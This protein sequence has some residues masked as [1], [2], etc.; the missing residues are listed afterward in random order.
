MPIRDLTQNPKLPTCPECGRHG[1]QTNLWN[2]V[3]V[4]HAYRMSGV[5]KVLEDV[6]WYYREGLSPQDLRQRFPLISAARVAPLEISGSAISHIRPRC[7]QYAEQHNCQAEMEAELNALIELR[8][9]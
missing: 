3:E 2:G 1:T 9:F 8:G 5:F 4:I 7:R 6:C